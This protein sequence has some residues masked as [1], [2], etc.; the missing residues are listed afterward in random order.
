MSHQ[1]LTGS[2]RD[3]IA[4]YFAKGHSRRQIA[5]RLDRDP[6]TI[7]RE[8]LRNSV[9]GKYRALAAH[10]Q[11]TTRQRGQPPRKMDAPEI[12]VAVKSALR[13]DHSPEVIAGR[14]KRLDGL[15]IGRQAIYDWIG[16][17]RQVGRKWHR[18]L[19]RCGKPYARKQTGISCY[20]GQKS[21]QERSPIV[22]TRERIGDWEGDT[23]E[24]RKG[25]DAV[26]VLVERTS[27]YTALCK[28]E[29]R[30]ATSLNAAVKARF[31]WQRGFP[32]ETLTVDRGREFADGTELAV[33]F[34]AAVYFTDPHSPWQKGAVEQVN[35][36][37]RRY[38]P[39]G[40]DKVTVKELGFAA[41]RLN[42]RPRKCLG[43]LT[44]HEV[45]FGV[46]PP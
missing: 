31:R 15:R 41:D 45:L 14:L 12:A 46:S 37:L 22:E 5:I 40:F 44:P 16:R 26:V 7:S 43:F 25:G 20:T 36:L 21:I 29:D 38:L 19:P 11:A 17:E 3:T 8:V 4:E 28:V 6:S 42:H 13:Q 34:K 27:R 9:T 30:R 18:Y 1:H 24:G 39:K 2:E 35:G 33:A 23:L 10:T 32:R